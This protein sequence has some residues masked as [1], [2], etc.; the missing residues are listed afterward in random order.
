MDEYKAT[1]SL[2]RS[3]E[4]ME[5]LHNGWILYYACLAALFTHWFKKTK[6]IFTRSCGTPIDPATCCPLKSGAC[7]GLK[8]GVLMGLVMASSFLYMPISAS[9][10]I[11]WLLA[12]VLQ[13]L[14]VGIILG[15]TCRKN[16]AC[17]I[18]NPTV[19]P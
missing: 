1:S 14:G 15:L 5:I 10:A 8:I 18:T 11:K 16:N 9:L 2:W 12:G 13:G 19:T 7:F 3:N 4:E 6:F 17:Q